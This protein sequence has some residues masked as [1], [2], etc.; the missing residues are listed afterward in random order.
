MGDHEERIRRVAYHMWLDEGRPE[1]RES[2]HWQK[3][4]ELVATQEGHHHATA[5]PARRDTA[6]AAEPIALAGSA[7]GGERSAHAGAGEQADPPIRPA[8]KQAAEKMSSMTKKTAKPQT[9]G[10]GSTRPRTKK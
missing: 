10:G 8:A 5:M 3:A 9:A 6:T 7:K 2:A 1:G 4:R